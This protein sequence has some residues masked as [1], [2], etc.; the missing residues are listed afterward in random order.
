MSNGTVPTITPGQVKDLGSALIQAI[1]TDIPADVAQGWIGNKAALHRLLRNHLMPPTPTEKPKLEPTIVELGEFEVNYDETIAGKLAGITDPKC[2]GWHTASAT[3][4]HFPDARKGK[5]RFKASAISF[6][7]R[8][9]HDE[10][11]E[12]WCKDNKKIRATPK[13]GIDIAHV[14]PYPKLGDVMPLKMAGQFFVD[15]HDYRCSLYFSD[16]GVEVKRYL[17]L[18]QRVPSVQCGVYSWFLVLE[19]LLPSN[20]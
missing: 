1:P 10:D 15:A 11:V 20:A 4:E 13:E 3:D 9:M 12:Q 8:L 19:E 5:K 16:D 17:N 7:D 18:D 2:I 6:S 14:S